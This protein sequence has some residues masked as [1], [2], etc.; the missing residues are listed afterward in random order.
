[1]DGPPGADNSVWEVGT[2]GCDTWRALGPLRDIVKCL[3]SVGISGTCGEM[4]RCYN[5]LDELVCLTK[6]A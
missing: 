6:S 3:I 4:E 1:M 5:N 2:E